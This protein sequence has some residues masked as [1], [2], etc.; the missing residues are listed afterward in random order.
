METQDYCDNM[1]A[2]LSGW[3]SKIDNVVSKFDHA[4]SNDK[5]GVIN[6]VNELHKIGEEFDSRI[7]GLKRECAGGFN[8]EK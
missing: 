2:E 6:E 4:S 7:K 8:L 5:E 3:K 1:M